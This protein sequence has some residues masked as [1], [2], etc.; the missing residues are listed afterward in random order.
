MDRSI[1]VVEAAGVLGVILEQV[2]CWKL[3]VGEDLGLQHCIHLSTVVE[4]PAI[5]FSSPE[6]VAT[7]VQVLRL[8]D[9][10]RQG[11]DFFHKF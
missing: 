10:N 2:C 11:L 7:P 4:L 9:L 8:T 1:L 3:V 5:I 6:L